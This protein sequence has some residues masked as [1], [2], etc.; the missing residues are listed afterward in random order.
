MKLIT[1]KKL[2]SNKNGKIQLT[3]GLRIF[4]IENLVPNHNEKEEK[5]EQQFTH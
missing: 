3:L 4:K 1:N 2:F 5:N